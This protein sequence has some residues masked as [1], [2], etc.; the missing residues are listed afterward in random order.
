M[1]KVTNIPADVNGL[2]EFW[3]REGV[4]SQTN[5]RDVQNDILTYLSW[6]K[7]LIIARNEL[8][9]DLA[10]MEQEYEECMASHAKLER[11][12][13]GLYGDLREVSKDYE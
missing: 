4:V 1:G 5:E 9:T 8:E 2:L 3:G 13:V 6:I 11:K 12:I 7:N 10:E